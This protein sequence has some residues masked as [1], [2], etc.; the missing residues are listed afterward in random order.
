MYNLEILTKRNKLMCRIM[1]L[2]SVLFIS[3]SAFSGVNKKSLYVMGPL[4]IVTS[5]L[6][7]FLEAK[8]IAKTK[9]MYINSVVLALMH[10]IFTSMFHDLNCLLVGIVILVIISLYQYYK[11]IFITG[12]L[13]VFNLSYGYFTG[14]AKMY[15]TF[16]NVLGLS[17]TVFDFSLVIL[18]LCLGSNYTEKIRREVE[19][20]K[21]EAEKN[22]SRIQN[23]FDS[24]KLYIDTLVSFNVQLKDNVD[25]TGK[26]SSEVTSAFN[27]ISS[28]VENQV[29]ILENINVIVNRETDDTG[30]IV[31]ESN[32]MR[33]LSGET[34][35]RSDDGNK[36]IN[37]LSN[38]M[39]IVTSN[40][41]ETVDL[42]ENLN[43][44]A[45]N[46]GTILGALNDISEQINL[47]ALNAA[48]EAARA[49]EHGKGFSV[50]A[51]E[52]RKLAE[53]SKE[54]NSE[55]AEILGD[56]KHKV[57]LVSNQ[58]GL[59][60][61][62]AN[63]SS[64]SVSVVANLFNGINS[65]SITVVNKAEEVNKMASK[66]DETSAEILGKIT[67]ITGFTQSTSAS[68]EEVLNSAVEQNNRVS[69]IVKSFEVLENLV[70]ELKSTSE[71]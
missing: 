23:I 8:G 66:I 34:L 22:K 7:T 5:L 19:M 2:I 16:H 41:K 3:F 36:Y 33:F 35:S 48:I 70:V 20:Q 15:G 10:L 18:L 13:I 56:I 58:I 25:V 62:S 68:V 21:E 12:I 6:L 24:L 30:R 49:G 39:M 4:L 27:E 26:I 42:M 38:E 69:E 47:L 44:Q 60:Q 55:I 1:W 11:V 32:T 59:V 57:D 51:D 40:V 14:G 52:V 61:K 54:S 67:E 17:I 65:N 29:G 46:I 71:Q 64:D 45:N 31:K 9:M 50:V 37:N 28:N 63:E 53:Q 43:L